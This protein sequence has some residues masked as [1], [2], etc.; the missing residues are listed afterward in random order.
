VLDDPVKGKVGSVAAAF[1]LAVII[2]TLNEGN[3]VR[4]IVMYGIPTPFIVAWK[5]RAGMRARESEL[6]GLEETFH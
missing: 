6:N 5:F 1:A 2:Y 3:L 4:A